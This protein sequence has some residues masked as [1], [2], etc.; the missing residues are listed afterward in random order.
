MR[1]QTAYLWGVWFCQTDLKTVA[2]LLCCNFPRRQAGSYATVSVQGAKKY[3]FFFIAVFLDIGYIWKNIQADNYIAL[4]MCL[5]W[6]PRFQ[7]RQ[8][9]MKHLATV[10]T[11]SAV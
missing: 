2:E 3:F 11:K 6:F 5:L 7:R 9:F 10:S 8:P 1:H 4:A